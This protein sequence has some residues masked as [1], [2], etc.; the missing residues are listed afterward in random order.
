MIFNVTWTFLFTSGELPGLV[1][2]LKRELLGE[3]WSIVVLETN[4]PPWICLLNRQE[5]WKPSLS[6]QLVIFEFYGLN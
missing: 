3:S 1:L 5:G 2:D 6:M 4:L